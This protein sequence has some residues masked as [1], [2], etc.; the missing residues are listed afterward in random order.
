MV[1][2]RYLLDTNF[3]ID[4]FVGRTPR[5][6]ARVEQCVDGELVTSAIV[7]AEVMIGARTRN[8]QEVAEAFFRQVAVL[9]FERNA[10][11][12]YAELPFERGNFDRLIAAHALSL[13]LTLVTSN[14]RDF[15]GISGMAVENWTR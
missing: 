8:Q 9:P 7:Y 11:D 14:E 2:P 3:C 15:A 12:T 6:A 1:E 4:L 5:G 10:G 13:G